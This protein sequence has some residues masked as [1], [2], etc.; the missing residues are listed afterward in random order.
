M[1]LSR[2]RSDAD[3]TR[4]AFCG[5]RRFPRSSSDHAPAPA[6]ID[7]HPAPPDHCR[8]TVLPHPRG[9]GAG[10]DSTR[11]AHA[12]LLSHTERR[13]SLDLLSPTTRAGGVVRCACVCAARP[14]RRPEGPSQRKGGRLGDKGSPNSGHSLGGTGWPEASVDPIGWSSVGGVC[15]WEREASQGT[16]IS[17]ELVSWPLIDSGPGSIDKYVDRPQLVIVL[18]WIGRFASQ[19]IHPGGRTSLIRSTPLLPSPTRQAGKKAQAE[20]PC[21]AG[22]IKQTPHPIT[23]P[24]HHEPR[25]SGAGKGTCDGRNGRPC[26]A[27]H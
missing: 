14:P 9:V 20:L 27:H 13:L 21:V 5:H 19:S 4:G 26:L 12:G 10:I 3:D 15:V 23:T 18:E 7:A 2:R 17:G 22:P 11:A 25:M 1:R 6:R 8:A 16:S 24:T